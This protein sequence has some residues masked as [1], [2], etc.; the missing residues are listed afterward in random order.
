MTTL[1][2]STDIGMFG[3][4]QRHVR[5]HR[6]PVTIV[7]GNVATP[8]DRN[9][10]V[11]VDEFGADETL[12]G[13][14]CQCCTVRAKLQTA[15]RRLLVER[16]KG[17]HFNRVV[18]ETSNDLGP[19]LRT[20]ATERTL[21]EEFHVEEY[22]APPV[23]DGIYNFVLTEDVP[24]SWDAFSRF[25]ATLMALRGADL[26]HVKGLLNVTGCRGPV[27]AQFLQHL[28]HRPVELQAW[29][30]EDRTSRLEFITRGI[31]ENE[32]RGLFDSIRILSTSS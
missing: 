28:A 25:I 17:R 13:S 19:I 15:L 14:G 32:V 3:R 2:P 30:N 22:P 26:L 18:I 23:I 27:A 1:F 31:A 20:F 8:Q 6:I 5:G 4:R 21:G 29:R 10:V 24:L 11:V 9:M 16:E 7:S 12:L